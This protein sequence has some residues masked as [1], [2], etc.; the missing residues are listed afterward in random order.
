M[1]KIRGALGWPWSSKVEFQSFG[2]G[3]AYASSNPSV[4]HAS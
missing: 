2:V 4:I 3:A 1:W